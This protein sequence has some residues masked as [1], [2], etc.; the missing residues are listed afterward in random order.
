MTG[1]DAKDL[2]QQMHQFFIFRAHKQL[3]DDG[4]WD[5]DAQ[6]ASRFYSLGIL[7]PRHS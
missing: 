1:R 6:F 3:I 4:F 5:V 2:F 7:S